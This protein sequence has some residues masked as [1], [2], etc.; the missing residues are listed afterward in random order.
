VVRSGPR[1]SRDQTYPSDLVRDLS[2]AS[3]LAKLVA[4]WGVGPMPN[5]TSCHGWTRAVALRLG[6]EGTLIPWY[7]QWPLAPLQMMW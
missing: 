3:L 4:N 6:A 2:L 7:R 5:L 1:S